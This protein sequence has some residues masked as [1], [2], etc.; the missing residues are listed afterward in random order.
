MKQI[1]IMKRM[2]EAKEAGKTGLAASYAAMGEAQYELRSALRRMAEEAR[3]AAERCE[4]LARQ[5]EAYD[6]E[7]ETLPPI[8]WNSLGILQSSGS[9]IDRLCGETA[10]MAKALAAINTV[11]TAIEDAE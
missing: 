1:E 3:I 2:T 10:L 11:T 8:T 7:A 4:K 5:A 6:T 9:G